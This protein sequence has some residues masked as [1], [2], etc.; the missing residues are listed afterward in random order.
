MDNC[1]LGYI[2][3]FFIKK[4]NSLYRADIFKNYL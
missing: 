1:H 4:T 3:S 2:T